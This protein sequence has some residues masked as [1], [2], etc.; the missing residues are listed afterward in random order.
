MLGRWEHWRNIS[1]YSVINSI[2]RIY[3]WNLIENFG[4]T[5]YTNSKFRRKNFYGIQRRGRSLLAISL[6]LDFR[7]TSLSWHL[8]SVFLKSKGFHVTIAISKSRVRM[9]VMG[10]N[11]VGRMLITKYTTILLR[12]TNQ[13]IIRWDS[14]SRSHSLNIY[15]VAHIYYIV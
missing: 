11:S 3:R 15:H 2:D 4:S 10:W 5:L 8:T 1:R 14:F 6:L 7:E 13:H 9:C 12:S